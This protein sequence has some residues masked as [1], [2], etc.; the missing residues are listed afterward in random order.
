MGLSIL[1]H[2][3]ILPAIYAG[4]ELLPSVALERRFTISPS[5]SG[6]RLGKTCLVAEMC[7]VPI[8]V[9]DP[10]C[11]IIESRLCSRNALYR[12]PYCPEDPVHRRLPRVRQDRDGL[13]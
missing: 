2:Q 3:C 8:C 7:W 5:R 12:T 6:R 1:L 13:R 10:S 11:T 9:C 4:P